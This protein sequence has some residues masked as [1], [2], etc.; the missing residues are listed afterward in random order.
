M[1]ERLVNGET[2]YSRPKL[3]KSAL[4]SKIVILKGLY[5]GNKHFNTKY[6]RRYRKSKI[7]QASSFSL[8]RLIHLLKVLLLSMGKLYIYQSAL[9]SPKLIENKVPFL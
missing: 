8:K 6:K 9:R 2:R 1:C 3:C 5:H 4:R 7:E